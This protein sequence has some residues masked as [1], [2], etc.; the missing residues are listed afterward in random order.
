M[1]KLTPEQKRTE[2]A[3]IDKAFLKL[4]RICEA[5][6]D[7]DRFVEQQESDARDHA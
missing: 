7:F 3:K 4:T 2:Q 5:T 6:R 1:T